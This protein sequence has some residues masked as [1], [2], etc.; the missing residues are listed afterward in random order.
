[1]ADAIFEDPRLARVYDPLDPDRSDLDVYVA[2]A[3]ELG[4]RSVLDIGCGTGTFGCL[5]AQR[6][7]DVTAVDPARASLDVA[8]SKPGAAAVRWL[9]GDATALPAMHVDAAFMTA[10]V[11]QVFLTDDD[12]AATLRGARDA[13]RPGGVLVFE[14]RDPARR[15]WEQWTPELT[16]TIVDVPG[17]GVVESWEEVTQVS[18]DLVTFRSMTAFRR[19]DLVLGSVSTLRFRDRLQVEASLA[20]EGFRMSEVRDAPDRPGRELVFLA[21][22]PD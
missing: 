1:V 9:L 7:L 22:R 12:W 17:V 18:G 10:N 3:D 4:A 16:R 19:D 15:A 14:T 20:Q 21:R 8:R 2:L 6:G 11:A 13:L 5:L